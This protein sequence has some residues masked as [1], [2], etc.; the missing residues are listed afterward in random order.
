MK[1]ARGGQAAAL[2][3]SALLVS[4]VVFRDFYVETA[5]VVVLMVIA[6]EAA[7]V[8]LATRKPETKYLLTVMGAEQGARRIVV[9]PGEKSV[10]WVRLYKKVGG[11]AEL[12]SRVPFLTIEPK[13]ARGRGAHQLDFSFETEYAGEYSG[14][15]VGVLVKGPL[16]FFSSGC[17]VPFPRKYVV[18]PRVLQVAA[19]TVR[20]LGRTEIGGTPVQMPG[21]GSEYYEM[22]EYQ[23][24]D[25]Y[26][27][28]NWKATARLGELMVVEHMRESG[29][30]YLLVLDARAPG[31]KETDSLASTFLSLA[32]SLGA[33]GVSFGVLVHDGASVLDFASEQD[34]MASL[35][36]ALKAAVKIA[37]L[38]TSPEYL[39]LVPVGASTGA[40]GE[41]GS[42]AETVLAGIARLRKE[43]IESMLEAVDPWAAAA[44]FVRETQTRSVLYV[45]GLFGDVRPVIELAWQARHYRDAEFA[46]ANP[47]DG[48]GE[49]GQGMQAYRRLARGFR[50]AGVVYFRG[51]PLMLTR[52]VLVV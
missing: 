17:A 6:S 9:Y 15:Q 2:V 32:N 14:E 21:V 18:Y 12:V 11:E 30:S 33:A 29:G 51:D 4:S 31:F 39:E 48:G 26:R 52:Q 7:W 41:G 44:R 34:P 45:S 13:L 25:D 43:E 22:R 40:A 35:S 36:R 19:S 38:D 50:S 24:G 49:D 3:A 23:P 46:V 27:S 16:G 28:V 37:K 42:G 47:C 10:D 1:L 5:L 20:L 8:R